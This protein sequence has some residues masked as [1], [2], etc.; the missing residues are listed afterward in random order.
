MSSE[1]SPAGSSPTR[2]AG[3]RRVGRLTGWLFAAFIFVSLATPGWRTGPFTW[4]PLLRFPMLAGRPADLGLLSLLPGLVVGGWLIARARERPQRAWRWGRRGITWP[5][6]G[7][8][9]LVLVSLDWALT[10]RT[11]VQAVGLGLAWLTYLFVVNKRPNLTPSLALVV[12]VQGGVALGQFWCQSDLGL[13]F[14]G[15]LPLDPAASGVSVVW[16]GGRRWLRAYGLT[17][18][19]NLLGASLVLLLLWLLEGSGRARGWRRAGLSLAF[20]L[21]LLGLIVSFSRAAWLAFGLGV[22]VWG[23]QL[24]RGSR[25]AAGTRAERPWRVGE[26][27]WLALPLLL[28]GLVLWLCRDLAL[29]RFV[30]LSTPTEARSLGERQRDTGLALDLIADHPWWGVGAGNY[31]PA[32]RERRPKSQPVHNVLLLVTAELGLLGAGLWLWLS[33]AGLRAPPAALGPWL[34]TIVIGLFDVSLWLT[35]SWRAAILF[36]LLLAWVAGDTLVRGWASR[37]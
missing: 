35:T 30:N 6:L 25:R 14:L 31:V 2:S 12:S 34:A 17:G 23:W 21:G 11:L 13:A 26:L 37:S 20:S 36:G 32:V 8:S 15:E 10:W 19:P 4:L 5:L 18:H 7:L 28:G 29:S 9:L 33:L 16:A 27:W 3:L 24:W 1:L 22:G